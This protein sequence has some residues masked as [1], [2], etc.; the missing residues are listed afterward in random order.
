MDANLL[1][2]QT[3]GRP[4]TGEHMVPLIH[5]SGAG[6]KKYKYIVQENENVQSEW[7]YCRKLRTAVS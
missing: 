7:N 3:V 1:E 6:G 4:L 5:L 2:E